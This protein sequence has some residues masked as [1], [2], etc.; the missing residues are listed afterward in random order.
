MPRPPSPFQPPVLRD[1]LPR[2]PQVTQLIR[3][4]AAQ[5]PGPAGVVQAAGSSILSPILYVAFTQQMRDDGSLLPRDREPCLA[6][7]VNGIGL[8]PG[9][10]LGRLASS[11]NSLP[12]YEI[13]SSQAFSLNASNITITWFNVIFNIINSV[14]N[15]TNTVFNFFGSIYYNIYN[16]LFIQGDGYL[17]IGVATEFCG[18]MFWCCTSFSLSGGTVSNL[19]L[20]S[21][22]GF[23]SSSYLGSSTTTSKI[24][25]NLSTTGSGVSIDGIVPQAFGDKLNTG[26]ITAATNTS[27]ITITVPGWTTQPTVGMAV[28][29][30]GVNGNTAAN[31]TW[32]INAIGPTTIQLH[33]STGNGT[34]VASPG[35]T[36]QLI[37]PE[38]IVLNNV[39][40]LPIKLV[41]N[42]ASASRNCNQFMLPPAWEFVDLI[43]AENDSVTLWWDACAAG[44]WRVIATTKTGVK[45]MLNDDQNTTL[46]ARP[47]INF[48]E[49][50]NVSIT[51]D[52][53]EPIDTLDVTIGTDG[54]APGDE[55]GSSV[56][57]A[58]YDITGT[59]AQVGGVQ[60]T[61][62]TAGTYLL[63][64]TSTIKINATMGS[65]WAAIRLF[66]D[67]N[68]L[69]L[70]AT[71]Q[72]A[73]KS[74][75]ANLDN[76]GSATTHTVYPDVAEDTVIK[77]Q[78]RTDGSGTINLAQCLSDDN[79]QGSTLL[80]YIR[81]A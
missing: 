45:I 21:G 35:S 20:L 75:V 32:T 2:Y 49:G 36:I 77:L 25:Y 33:A 37:G 57:S 51:I 15:I 22:S 62:P 58:N 52:D 64:A 7:D 66:D 30:S 78:A 48:I 61:I 4:T 80:Q 1:D 47:R 55:N 3:V 68:S 40:A 28:K 29:V 81:I 27:P 34:F 39:G 24:V 6:D 46:G 26:D 63:I 19:N 14:V 8:S 53:N 5:V 13:T 50:T 79:T 67:T 23:T 31:G 76:M 16:T 44:Q 41:R 10:Y 65:N 69:A 60:I 38:L 72:T 18:D 17:Y 9:F 43:L 11:F 70:S 42:N 74:Q 54:S 56:L 59:W 73:V 12:V 71:V